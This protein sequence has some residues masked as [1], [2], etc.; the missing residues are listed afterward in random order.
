LCCNSPRQFLAKLNAGDV[1]AQEFK[2]HP[3]CL[4]ALYNRERERV[5]MRQE[6]ESN[7]NDA[8]IAEL[9][10]YI[11]ETQRNSMESVMF[12]LAD[13]ISVYEE[14]LLQLGLNSLPVH[15]NQG[16]HTIFNIKFQG[17]SRI[18]FNLQG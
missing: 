8:S 2:Y 15:T 11:F 4:V 17:I 12:R 3:A 10:S 16:S 18:F 5:A 14:R 13:L 7:T 6:D 9:V 1:I